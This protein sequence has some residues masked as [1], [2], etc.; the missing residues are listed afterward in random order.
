MDCSLLKHKVASPIILF[1]S[2]LKF[3]TVF[4]IAWYYANDETVSY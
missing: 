1:S 3:S 2:I 4:N